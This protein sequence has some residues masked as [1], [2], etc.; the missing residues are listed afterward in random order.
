MPLET[1]LTRNPQ[2]LDAIYRLRF[3]VYYQELGSRL[4]A[5]VI[6]AGQLQDEL[7]SV[8]YH[9]ASFVDGQV[10]GCVRVFDLKDLPEPASLMGKY[11][12]RSAVETFGEN[13]ITFTGRL[14]LA[15]KLRKSSLVHRLMALATD[16]ARCRGIRLAFLDCS[17]HHL[18][19]YE[20]FG[21]RRYAPAF[22]DPVFGFKQPL[23]FILRD[24]IGLEAM[25]SPL[26]R[27][28]QPYEDDPETRSW[29][30]QHYGSHADI[31][32]ATLLTLGTFTDWLEQ[33]LATNLC[34]SIPLFRGLTRPELDLVLKKSTMVTAQPGDIVNRPDLQEDFM[35]VVLR[36]A[37]EA[38]HA[39]C[40]IDRLVQGDIFGEGDFLM[41]S[42]RKLEVVALERSELL[43]LPH[44]HVTYLLDKD[45]VIARVLFKNLAVCL[46]TRAFQRLSVTGR[47]PWSEHGTTSRHHELQD[48]QDRL[49]ENN[50]QSL[51][52]ANS[53]HPAGRELA[54]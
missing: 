3:E 27:S 41:G 37:L 24:K 20:A 6:E 42:R 18:P 35:C 39:G 46:A 47:S 49:D 2:E 12:L 28:S 13:P 14:V 21:F 9:Y 51:P 22:S 44:E 45:L 30:D 36:G 26:A 52:L 17:P 4:P 25:G 34:E 19:F 50:L 32:T 43:I 11:S 40:R 10:V 15:P 31:Q 5:D 1:R 33:R 29:Y 54:L 16:E 8:A 53:S 23:L 7:D 38:K 48:G